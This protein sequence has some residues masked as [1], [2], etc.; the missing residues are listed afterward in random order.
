MLFPTQSGRRQG[1]A[2]HLE[3]FPFLDAMKVLVEEDGGG[4]WKQQCRAGR[5]GLESLLL[6]LGSVSVA[7]R[8]VH[9]HMH[10]ACFDRECLTRLGGAPPSQLS[11]C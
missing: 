4:P 7:V 3:Q 6:F 8:V 5:T 2:A 9:A 1:I 11:H 10:F